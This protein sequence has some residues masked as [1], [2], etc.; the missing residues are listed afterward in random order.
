MSDILVKNQDEIEIMIKAQEITDSVFGEIL[1]LIKADMT[2]IELAKLIDDEIFS[3]GCELAFD[4]IVAFG[5]NSAEMHHEPTI[6][7]LKKND[8]ILFDL[9][10]KY[11]G[12]CSDMSRTVFFG[13]P[14][15]HF[16]EIYDLVLNAQTLALNSICAGM[17]GKQADA[18][19]REYLTANGYGAE[20]CH[21]LGHG[22]G[23]E[24]HEQPRLGPKDD[25]ILLENM[26]V[27]VEP[28][29]YIAGFGGVRIEDMVIVKNGGVI[30]LTKTHKN[31]I[32]N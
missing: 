19:A 14:S 17:S 8:I 7:T 24:I 11:Q 32:I 18:L 2:E 3:N 4:T 27:T 10:A 30:N 9:G 16:V 23:Q 6:R 25:T 1:G 20:F 28:G 13:T 26:V 29:L 31:Y 22:V 21:T 15:E 5:E 12:Y